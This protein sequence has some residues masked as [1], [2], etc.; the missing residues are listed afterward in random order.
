MI[1]HRRARRTG[2]ALWGLITISITAAAAPTVAAQ[3]ITVCHSTGSPTAPWVYLT[4]DESTWPEH[5]AH[6]DFRASSAAECR[7]GTPTPVIAQPALG[8]A[9]QQQPTAT[10][11][12]TATVAAT[13]SPAA[14]A[15]PAATVRPAATLAATARPTAAAVAPT[16]EVAGATVLPP[17]GE[18]P[19]PAVPEQVLLAILFATGAVGVVLR[20]FGYQQR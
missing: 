2:L 13:P 9:V 18:P 8:P 6:G 19:Q 4:V 12:A 14:T 11:A 15:I 17:S 20:L 16:P 7:I 5:Q 3:P 10:L 1:L